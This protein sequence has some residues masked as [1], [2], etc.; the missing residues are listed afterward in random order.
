MRLK[1]A[2]GS[3]GMTDSLLTTAFEGGLSEIANDRARVEAFLRSNDFDAKWAPNMWP[4][5][6][7][8]L[9]LKKG[10]PSER[11]D[12]YI[13]ILELIDGVNERIDQ[14]FLDRD[15]VILDPLA[16]GYFL[17]QVSWVPQH[18]Q[19]LLIA[20]GL[21]R[22][23]YTDAEMDFTLFSRFASL[24][25][26]ANPF[27]MN[28]MEAIMDRRGAPT[29]QAAL[30]AHWGLPV[31]EE[32][33]AAIAEL[34]ATA[35][36]RSAKSDAMDVLI[37]LGAV[38]RIPEQ[39]L[40]TWYQMNLVE[41]SVPLRRRKLAY[42]MKTPSGRQALLSKLAD[43]SLPDEVQSLAK[44]IIGSHVDATKQL[45][46]FDLIDEQELRRLEAAL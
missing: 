15:V 28:G 17:E 13:K 1:L 25:L 5:F 24:G 38:D 19:S 39:Q 35:K 9:K 46:R 14:V 45:K 10:S 8:V 36:L 7:R 41:A 40:T 42:L 12:A 22:D 31:E 32:G 2:A 33:V 34:L 30:A 16:R 27:C 20:F 11:A 29:T 4:G 26:G 3:F 44:S 23:S 21:L 43:G 37:L 18:Q 6:N